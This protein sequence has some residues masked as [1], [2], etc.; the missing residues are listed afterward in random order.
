VSRVVLAFLIDALGWETL[1]GRP[2]LDAIIRTRCPLRSVLG[3]SSGAEPSI[4]TGLAPSHHG[5]WTM[6]R[7]RC[8]RSPLWL[9]P[10]VRCA[11]PGAR[12]RFLTWW[13]REREGVRGYFDLY[14]VPI[15]L[16]PLFDL[17]ERTDLFDVGGIP[18]HPTLFDTMSDEGIPFRAWSWRSPEARN[19]A[20]L[21]RTIDSGEGTFCFFYTAALDALQHGKGPRAPEVGEMIAT[22]E[23]RIGSVYR[24]AVARGRAPVLFVFSDHGMTETAGTVDLISSV[25][26]LGLAAPRDYL[27]FYDSTMARFWFAGDSARE[28]V[29]GLLAGTPHGRI[30]GDDELA[31]EGVLFP[32]RRYGE[33]IFLMDVGWQIE[34]SYM[35]RRAPRGMHGFHPDA[36]SSSA[37]LLTDQALAPQPTDIR[38]LHSLLLGAARE[39]A[40]G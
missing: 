3:F 19:F 15:P 13:V 30:V 18:G 25:E 36:P 29:A 31:R 6:Y 38:D 40:R 37:A 33:L 11:P 23:E 34:P 27:A 26:A 5:R 35:G 10:W 24:R 9:A 22:L 8:G 4:L 7:R 32:D 16:L 39:A 1:S 28:R 20:E 14:D 21:E 2:F 12:R 17:P